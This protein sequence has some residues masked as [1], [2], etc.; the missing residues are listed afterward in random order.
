M[1]EFEARYT[2]TSPDSADYEYARF[3]SRGYIHVEFGNGQPVWETIDGR[4][5]TLVT[6][7][8]MQAR[9]E[10]DGWTPLESSRDGVFRYRRPAPSVTYRY[11][12]A[13]C[14]SLGEPLTFHPGNAEETQAAMGKLAP[15]I[16]AFLRPYLAAGWE[17]DPYPSAIEPQLRT[18]LIGRWEVVAVKV[19]L[20]TTAA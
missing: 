11:Q 13:L 10:D 17:K 3:F 7:P 16:E 4:R 9:L 8:E 6:A 20:R 15:I 5:P 19:R 2:A 12:D 1:S 14:R 18:H